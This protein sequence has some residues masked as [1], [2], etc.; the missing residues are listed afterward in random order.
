MN[1]SN[2]IEKAIQWAETYG[3]K[4]IKAN[5]EG[6]PTPTQYLPKKEGEPFVP[7][8]SGL[9]SGHKSYVEIATKTDN[10]QRKVSKWELLSTLAG[11]KGGKLFLL[12]PRGHKSFADE[13]VKRYQLRAEVIY[14]KN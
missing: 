8:I 12:A 4:K 6:Y 10:L 13:I 2:L 1:K 3:F 7:D 14:L 11:M 5:H 9:R